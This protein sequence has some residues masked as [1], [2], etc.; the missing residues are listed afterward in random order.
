MDILVNNAGI[1]L[2]SGDGD[3]SPPFSL[4]AARQTLL[5][6]FDGVVSLTEAFLPLL[7][8]APGGG[9]VLTTSSAVGSR[10]MGLLHPS[11]ASALLRPSLTTSDLRQELSRLVDGLSDVLNPYHATIPTVAYGLSKCGVNVW[12]QLAASAYPSLR[13]NACSP[14]FCATDM[15]KGYTGLRRA[16][17]PALGASVFEHVLF[18]ELGRG[19]TGCFFKENSTPD[20]DL[21]DAVSAQEEWSTL[22]TGSKA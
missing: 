7:S 12:T 22:P 5:V 2:E 19:K 20:T 15:C 17:A 14:G 16:K 13:V 10:T 4:T 1:L 11:D 3:S 8:L 18:G 9:H 6:N 21:K